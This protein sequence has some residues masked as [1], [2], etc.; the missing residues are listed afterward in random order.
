MKL[1]IYILLFGV[2]AFVLRRKPKPT[3]DAN[4]EWDHLDKEIILNEF[5]G[6]GANVKI[7]N[8]QI[9]EVT[10]LNDS[11]VGSLREALNQNVHREIIVKV[12]GTI[13]LTKNIYVDSGNFILRGNAVH[14]KGGMLQLEASNIVV[15]NLK[16]SNAPSGYDCLS[17][18]A[19][20]GKHHKNIV[21]DHLDLSEADDEN[22][23]IRGA[24]SVKNVTVQHCKVT[25]NHY[26]ML[27]IGNVANVSILYNHFINN[28]ERNIRLNSLYDG[29]LS[30][31]M[32]NN[33][34]EGFRSATRISLGSKTSIAY[35]TYLPDLNDASSTII[36][37]Y[38]D[39][40][41][42]GKEPQ[43]HAFIHGNKIPEGFT[44]VG[45]RLKPYLKT[46]PFKPLTINPKTTYKDWVINNAGTK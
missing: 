12:T 10:N 25:D 22:L 9:I 39:P 40:I 17:I 13:N 3:N 6:Y 2:L 31:E 41:S 45:D 24:G 7:E 32:I 16:I 37:G 42:E 11:G 5:L 36:K 15:S 29:E 1:L 30:F 43:T 20:E 23:N 46:T 33:V 27:I 34:F 4:F 19:W 35:N 14:L 44:L 18:T 26:G 28:E 38:N 21:L 8:A